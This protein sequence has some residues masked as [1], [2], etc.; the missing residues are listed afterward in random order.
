MEYFSLLT[1]SIPFRQSEGRAVMVSIFELFKIGIGQ[2]T[3]HTVGP[4][5]AAAAFLRGLVSAAGRIGCIGCEVILLGS[6][7]WTGHGHASD[8]AVLLGLSGRDAGGWIR[9]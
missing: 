2:T 7:A 3:S 5:R 6:L 4:M 9:M 1:A 8:K